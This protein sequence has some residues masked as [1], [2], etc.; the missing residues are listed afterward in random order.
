MAIDLKFK[1]DSSGNWDIDFA[2][3]D[4]ELTNGLDTAIYMSVFCEKRA[5]ASQV[6]DPT[7]RRGHF[8][9]DFNA[10]DGYEI[11][12][13]L[14]LYTTQA[15]NT[16]SNLKLIEGDVYEGL[17]WM[18]EDEIISKIEVSATKSGSGINLEVGLINKLQ[19]DSKYYNLFLA[20]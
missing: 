1:Q 6:S 18:I 13:L 7:S 12:S 11:G 17:K 16:E 5:S 19:K 4:F 2:N 20:T 8:T 9:N 3:G 15:K 14:W 10:V